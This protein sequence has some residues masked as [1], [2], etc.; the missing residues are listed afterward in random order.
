MRKSIGKIVV[1]AAIGLATVTNITYAQSSFD[2]KQFF[3][4]LQK[5]GAQL[6]PSFDPKKF[7]DDL[8]KQGAGSYDPKKFF[9][10][11]QQTGAKMPASFDPD[12]FFEDL[13]QQGAKVPSI[14]KM[15]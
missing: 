4:E 13:Q 12:K 14:I 7:F 6:P 11:L 15:K 9:E 2:P 8:Q 1:A 5:T 10:E 3:E